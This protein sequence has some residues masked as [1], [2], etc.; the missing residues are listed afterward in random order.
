[1]TLERF[2]Q[3]LSRQ[4]I[5]LW[6][7]GDSL[8]FR[9]PEGKLDARVRGELRRL[10]P[11]ILTW[12][13]DHDLE[14]L[15]PS[16]IR[17]LPDPER[18]HQ[19]FPL[20]DIQEGY[21]VGRSDLVEHGGIS[22]HTYQEVDFAELDPERFR[23]AWQRLIERHEMLRAVILPDGSQCLLSDVPPFAL[24]VEDL[25]A[26]TTER[27]ELH[28]AEL[29][30]RL[31]SHGP[32]IDQW[33]LFELR[34]LHLP[35]GRY[36]LLVAVSLLVADALSFRTLLAE[37]VW[38]YRQ[39]DAE[40]EPLELSFRDYVLALRAAEAGTPYQRS[41]AYWQ[42]RLATLPPAPDL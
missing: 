34:L 11:E 9:A 8:C 37:L 14:E 19:P 2:L 6:A 20:T 1:M 10:K 42:G 29:R 16:G 17:P 3:D 41:L 26:E 36:R 4:G 23:R 25:R 35:G 38:F 21:W 27:A 31:S 32:R 39:P 28:L 30:E 40:F 13:S 24:E 12:L 18:R 15:E 7:E 5:Q 22:A 33:P